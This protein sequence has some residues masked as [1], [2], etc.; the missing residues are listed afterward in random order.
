MATATRTTSVDDF[1]RD[2][3]S[4]G[5]HDDNALIVVNLS[6]IQERFEKWKREFP[7]V[8]PFFALKAQ[9]N[10]VTVQ[11]LARNGCGFDVA[12]LE[13]IRSVEEAGVSRD[14]ILYA[15]PYKQPSHLQYALKHGLLSVCDTV[16]ELHKVG[17]MSSALSLPARILLRILPDDK[18]GDTQ[19]SLSSN[20]L[21]YTSP[22]PRD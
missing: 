19:A 22:S 6:E 16:D 20:C 17:E 8:E 12:S 9:H 14:M 2:R 7:H 13:E 4:N 11:L 21:L 18:E 5:N 10:P 15:Q 1:V 3:L